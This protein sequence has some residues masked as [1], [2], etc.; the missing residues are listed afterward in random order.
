MPMRDFFGF[1]VAIL[2]ALLS[3]IVEPW[4]KTWWAGMTIAGFLAIGTLGHLIW[5]HFC[6]K[7]LARQKIIIE[8]L[9]NFYSASEPLLRLLTVYAVQDDDYKKLQADIDQWSLNLERYV[10]QELGVAVKSR[11]LEITVN[12]PH[13]GGDD[14]ATIWALVTVRKNLLE[15]IDRLSTQIKSSAC[16]C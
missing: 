10:V 1:M 2:I 4:S 11:L 14:V 8:R 13:G 3:Q 12:T 9:S 15:I 6:K 5:G 7:N 16:V